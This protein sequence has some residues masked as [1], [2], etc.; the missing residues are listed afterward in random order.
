[1]RQ[2]GTLSPEVDNLAALFLQKLE[3]RNPPLLLSISY[4]A[5]SDTEIL[6]L[7]PLQHVLAQSTRVHHP[8]SA[9]H[10]P[11]TL[12]TTLICSQLNPTYQYLSLLWTTHQ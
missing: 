3:R 10:I 5:G 12:T 2:A 6:Y 4:Y 11:D 1:M 8:P 9:H 7:V